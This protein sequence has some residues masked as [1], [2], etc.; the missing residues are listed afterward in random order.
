M[1]QRGNP[2]D[3]NLI[4]GEASS[5]RADDRGSPLAANAGIP[6]TESRV[7]VLKNQ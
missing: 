1:P 6:R 3:V 4:V 2:H 7:D 5:S